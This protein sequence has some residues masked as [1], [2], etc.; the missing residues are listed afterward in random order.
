MNTTNPPRPRGMGPYDRCACSHQGI[1]HAPDL[2]SGH[3]ECLNAPTPKERC[4]CRHFRHA[5]PI[6]VTQLQRAAEQVL[7]AI[8]AG[9]PG[10]ARSFITIGLRY[11]ADSGDARALELRA[12]LTRAGEALAGGRADAARRELHS[13]IA[14]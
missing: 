5:L 9:S 2:A 12:A 7:A 4:L 10:A 1:E 6:E 3:M 8:T 11:G 14:A 13:L